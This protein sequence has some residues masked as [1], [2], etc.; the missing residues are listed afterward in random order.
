MN[1]QQCQIPTFKPV[2]LS[3]SSLRMY[4]PEQK[5][6]RPRIRA[7]ARICSFRPQV[8]SKRPRTSAG[9]VRLYYGSFAG[10]V[11]VF[12]GWFS[13]IARMFCGYSTGT[14]WVI[15]KQI[16]RGRPPKVRGSGSAPADFSRPRYNWLLL[17]TVH[18]FI[19]NLASFRPHKKNYLILISGQVD[20]R[21]RVDL[22]LYYIN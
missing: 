5:S 15:L 12:C 17:R 21:R 9:I 19:G 8:R 18:V 20:F 14:S 1:N 6:V 4:S 2:W 16:I 13:G 10:A 22:F 7:P 11:R 3:A